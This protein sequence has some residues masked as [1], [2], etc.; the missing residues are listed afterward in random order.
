MFTKKYAKFGSKS[1][2]TTKHHM[3]KA[4]NLCQS[5]KCYASAAAVAGDI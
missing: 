5:I 2:S 4:T 3:F 1:Q